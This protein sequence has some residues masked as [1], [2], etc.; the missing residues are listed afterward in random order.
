M[1]SYNLLA[2]TFLFLILTNC[3]DSE[4]EENSFVLEIKNPKRTY[5]P[6]DVV[7]INLLNKENI[8]TDSIAYF[9]NKERLSISG[10]ALSLSGHKLGQ[11]TINAKIYKDGKEYMASQ[12]ITVVS[13]IR[14]KLYTYKVIVNSLP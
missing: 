2:I 4:K 1:K 14:P 9:L 12:N 10:D 8:D 6:N 7:S 13:P 3:G 11:R 5:T